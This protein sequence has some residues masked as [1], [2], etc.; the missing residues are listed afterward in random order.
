MA[1]LDE[2]LNGSHPK[3]ARLATTIFL[4]TG[5]LHALL[6]AA[7]ILGYLP[8]ESVPMSFSVSPLCFAAA[9]CLAARTDKSM[10]LAAGFAL[11]TIVAPVAVA[12]VMTW[13]K[14]HADERAVFIG[15]PEGSPG[16]PAH[17]LAAHSLFPLM[18]FV[19]P[20]LGAAYMG[21][22]ELKHPLKASTFAGLTWEGLRMLTRKDGTALIR[23]AAGVVI[24]L[25]G[26]GLA[27]F[28]TTNKLLN[29]GTGRAVV[30]IVVTGATLA[31]TALSFFPDS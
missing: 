15:E 18:M 11:A 30:G 25:L 16:D 20:G 10:L 17:N 31:A 26:V 19:I 8:W 14:R 3:A 12:D 23:L 27:F 5:V 22:R 24:I 2:F 28:L 1:I 13:R 9:I 4:L 6:G 29:R 21:R 7:G